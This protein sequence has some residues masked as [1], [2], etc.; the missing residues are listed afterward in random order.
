MHHHYL[1]SCNHD[2]LKVH[3][4][5]SYLQSG[6]VYDLVVNDK[7]SATIVDD[8]SS[9]TSTTIVESSANLVEET[10]LVNDRHALLDIAS[11]SHADKLTILTDVKDSV[12]LED[13]SEHAL[14][15]DGWLWVA[16]E[17]ALLVQLSCEEVD[18]EVSV[19]TG[20][21]RLRDS[22]DLAW[23]SL[24]DQKITNPDEVAWNCDCVA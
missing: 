3:S 13:R 19:L 16:A 17:R 22:D 20:L 14:D 6:A 2:I 12:L 5:C 9:D 8:K 24:E 23:S 1:A 10:T 7:L 21:A 15:N 11:L 18:A 4:I